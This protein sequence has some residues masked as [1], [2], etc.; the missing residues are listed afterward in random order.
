[1]KMMTVTQALKARKSELEQ[2]LA[3]HRVRQCPSLYAGHEDDA[4]KFVRNCLGT[5][6]KELLLSI[7]VSGLVMADHGG[8]PC[9]YWMEK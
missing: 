9:P 3:D 4:L 8:I 5:T 1:M 7:S 6:R 2:L